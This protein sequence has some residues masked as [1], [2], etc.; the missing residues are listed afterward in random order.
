MNECIPSNS[1]FLS[2]G[3]RICTDAHKLK[4]LVCVIISSQLLSASEFNSGQV[5]LGNA[6]QR[7]SEGGRGGRGGGRPGHQTWGGAKWAQFH[8][9]WACKLVKLRAHFSPFDA[10]QICAHNLLFAHT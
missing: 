8:A 10:T 1:G 7:C 5:L 6:I 4:C 2:F 9:L 3:E